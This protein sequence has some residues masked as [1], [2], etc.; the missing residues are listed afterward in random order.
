MNHLQF[1]ELTLACTLAFFATSCSKEN[2]MTA[3]EQNTSEA[4]L[5]IA[6]E[7]NLQ[8]DRENRKCPPDG[9]KCSKIEVLRPYEK[10]AFTNVIAAIESGNMDEIKTAFQ[11]E[12]S[13]L[14]EHI[15]K[16][17]IVE[18]IDGTKVPTV[19][20]NSAT[21]LHFISYDDEVVYAFSIE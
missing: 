17:L 5:K 2:P 18:T 10:S 20:F 4:Q 14:L 9:H 19:L 7:S 1:T 13:I 16:P 12:Y 21:K 6:G 3:V 11:N 8:W 15:A